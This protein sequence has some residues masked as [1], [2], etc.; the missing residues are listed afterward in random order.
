MSQ[1]IELAR[2]TTVIEFCKGVDEQFVSM[3]G[4]NFFS[5]G[6][7][8]K[9]PLVDPVLWSYSW[10]YC[11]CVI[12][13]DE[14]LFHYCLMQLSLGGRRAC[15]HFLSQWIHGYANLDVYRPPF[16]YCRR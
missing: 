14:P 9:Q 8:L 3:T 5:A 16:A 10:C 11:V 6:I 4:T 13:T 1:N 15:A 7:T 2:C 12:Q